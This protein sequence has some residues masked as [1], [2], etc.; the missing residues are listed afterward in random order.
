MTSNQPAPITNATNPASQAETVVRESSDFAT[1]ISRARYATTISN[2]IK[3]KPSASNA[4]GGWYGAACNLGRACWVQPV[5][6]E[7]ASEKKYNGGNYDAAQAQP[8]LLCLPG[9]EQLRHFDR[10][11]DDPYTLESQHEQQTW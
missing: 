4:T 6:G 8:G 10:Y 2:A 1:P 9:K 7:T 11:D 3:A 5:P